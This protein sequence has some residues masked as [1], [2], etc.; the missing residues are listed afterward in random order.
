MDL[1]LNMN[2]AFTTAMMDLEGLS[3]ATQDFLTNTDPSKKS[4][5]DSTS[6]DEP[7]LFVPQLNTSSALIAFNSTHGHL[8]ELRLVAIAS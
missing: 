1:D 2:S 5:H 6:L 7:D 4:W 3:E 8:T